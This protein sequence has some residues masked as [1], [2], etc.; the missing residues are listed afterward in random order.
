MGSLIRG[1]ACFVFGYLLICSG[2]WMYASYQY[3][4]S[5]YNASTKD[6]LKGGSIALWHLIDR[7]PL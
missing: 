4:S 1:C 2:Y 5:A 7:L 6:I 3:G